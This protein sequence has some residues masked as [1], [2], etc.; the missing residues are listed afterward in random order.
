MKIAFVL[1]YRGSSGGVR[2]TKIIANGLLARNHEV[3]IFFR[4]ESLRRGVRFILDKL[5]G[6]PD[7][8]GEFRG[9]VRA[10]RDVG[11]NEYDVP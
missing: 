6:A 7:W 1:P 4:R 5:Q 8:L 11:D 9:E 10:F 2:T 3:R